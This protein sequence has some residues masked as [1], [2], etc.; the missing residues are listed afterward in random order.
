VTRFSYQFAEEDIIS[1]F[2]DL[3]LGFAFACQL[4]EDQ[5]IANMRNL[6]ID[7]GK[8]HTTNRHIFGKENL[9]DKFA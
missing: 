4:V 2:V 8:A 3:M 1:P 9:P 6:N 5:D 7:K